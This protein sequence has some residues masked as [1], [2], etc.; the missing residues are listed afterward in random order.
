MNFS[1]VIYVM[2]NCGSEVI[3]NTTYFQFTVVMVFLNYIVNP[4][5]YLIKYIDYRC[6]KGEDYSDFLISMNS[7]T[8]QEIFQSKVNQQGWEGN[9][10][11]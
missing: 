9:P 3:F 7:V 1:I 2:H 10:Q 5:I 8:K 4:F 6:I 11:R